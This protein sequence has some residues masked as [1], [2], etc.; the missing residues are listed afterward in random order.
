MT[1]SSSRAPSILD[2]RDLDFENATLLAI[3]ARR[4][5]DLAQQASYPTDPLQALKAVRE[6]RGAAVAVEIDAPADFAISVLA[7]AQAVL[8]RKDF[9]NWEGEALTEILSV[10][11]SGLRQWRKQD[12]EASDRIRA[13]LCPQK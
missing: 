1:S 2:A 10:A 13:V 6:V 11:E 8:G 3:E 9:D 4:A 5:R 7:I 12:E